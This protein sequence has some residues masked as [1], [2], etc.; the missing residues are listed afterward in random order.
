MPEGTETGDFDSF[1]LIFNPG[2]FAVTADLIIYVEGLGRFTAPVGLRP[3]IPAKTR[4]TINMKDFLT[5]ME[6]AGGLAPGTLANTSFSTRVRSLSDGI[7]VEHALYRTLDGAN[8]W[9]S[10]SASFGVPR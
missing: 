6:Q 4:K 1:L 8:R 5:Q 2:D 3:V 10:G 7:V 9:R